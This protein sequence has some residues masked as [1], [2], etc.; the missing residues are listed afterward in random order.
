MDLPDD[1]GVA[2]NA[3]EQDPLP[4]RSVAVEHAAVGLGGGAGECLMIA[5]LRDPDLF[6]V[7]LQVERR[8]VDPHRMGDEEGREQHAL[9]VT[10]QQVHAGGELFDQDLARELAFVDHAAADVHRLVG[11]L[12]VEKRGVQGGQESIQFRGHVPGVS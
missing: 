6:H 11:A 8:V 4:E 1:R 7:V 5:V 3:A 10:R 12:D 2:G 9:A